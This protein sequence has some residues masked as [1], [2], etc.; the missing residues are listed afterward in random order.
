MSDPELTPTLDSWHNQPLAYWDPTGRHGVS[1]G[2]TEP[3]RVQW[4]LGC[5]A[6]SG[7]RAA[8]ER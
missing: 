7:L 2:P 6:T 8:I 5:A 3:P 4:R 1:N